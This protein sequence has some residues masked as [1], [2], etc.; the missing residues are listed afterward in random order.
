MVGDQYAGASLEG[1]YM[2]QTAQMD[3]AAAVFDQRQIAGGLLSLGFAVKFTMFTQLS[4]FDEDG[5]VDGVEIPAAEDAVPD[6][7]R[8]VLGSIIGIDILEQITFAIKHKH[9]LFRI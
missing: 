9:S 8:V 1:A 2:L 3:L 6:R 4:A 5:K 7:Y